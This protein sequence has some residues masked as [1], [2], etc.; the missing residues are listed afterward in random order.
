MHRDRPMLHR[1]DKF[2]HRMLCPRGPLLPLHHVSQL[3]GLAGRRLREHEHRHNYLVRVDSPRLYTWLTRQCSQASANP[4]CYPYIWVDGP[5][6]SYSAWQCGPST[7]PVYIN[8]ETTTLAT[9][10][11][12]VSSSS[13]TLNHGNGGGGTNA[14][15][16]AGGVVGGLGGCFQGQKVRPDAHVPL[17][18]LAVAVFGSLFLFR[19]HGRAKQGAHGPP[20]P[21]VHYDQKP[22]Y[23]G[24]AGFYNHQG[25][26]YDAAYQQ[27]GYQPLTTLPEL[28]P[29]SDHEMREMQG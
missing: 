22:G 14:G 26:Q 8:Q 2:R 20:F 3:R 9:T 13:T 12:V 27:G 28:P 29:T 18:V 11:T 21:G 6:Q 7:T 23:P 24:Y 17:A 25:Q 4:D 5:G 16:I 15:A 1:H 19:R 10:S